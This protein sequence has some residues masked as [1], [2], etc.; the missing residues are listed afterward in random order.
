[1]MPQ[2]IVKM[3]GPANPGKKGGKEQGKKT[4]KKKEERKKKQKKGD[5]CLQHIVPNTKKNFATKNSP[6]TTN[7]QH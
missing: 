6:T 2:I 7:Q 1:M 5:Q 3:S 4:K